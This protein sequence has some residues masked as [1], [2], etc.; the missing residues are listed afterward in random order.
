MSDNHQQHNMSSPG[1]EPAPVLFRPAKKR[2]LYRHRSE[3]GELANTDGASGSLPTTVV[4]TDGAQDDN[5]EE[6]SVADVLR[7]R[8]A[9]KHRTGGV[10]FRAGPSLNAESSTMTYENP[11]RSMVLHDIADGDSTILGGITQRFAP[12]TGLVGELVNKHM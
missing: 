4:V 5:G 1:A 6:R 8:N 10:A 7:L 3:E 12:Q 11:D 2:K 9:R